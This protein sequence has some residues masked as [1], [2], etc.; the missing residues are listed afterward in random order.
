MGEAGH[1]RRPSAHGRTC[2]NPTNAVV[3][4]LHTRCGKWPI[5]A[6]KIFWRTFERTFESALKRTRGGGCFGVPCAGRL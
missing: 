2:L 5:D 6:G 1:A 3:C 4:A